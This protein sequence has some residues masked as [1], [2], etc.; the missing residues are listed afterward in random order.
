MLPNMNPMLAH[1]MSQAH[2]LEMRRF[3][4]QEYLLKSAQLASPNRALVRW[5][6]WRRAGQP[7]KDS[8]VR[9]L[10]AAG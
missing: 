9:L 5:L 6:R 1:E 3:A 4:R 10:P 2:Q 8:R 7:D